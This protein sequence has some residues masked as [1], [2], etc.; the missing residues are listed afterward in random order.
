MHTRESLLAMDCS[1]VLAAIEQRLRHPV[2]TEIALRF[3]M[4]HGAA[5]GGGT[6]YTTDLESS[7][8]ETVDYDQLAALLNDACLDGKEKTQ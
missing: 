1:E 3:A 6:V 5:R 2:P 8:Q 7:W 4:A